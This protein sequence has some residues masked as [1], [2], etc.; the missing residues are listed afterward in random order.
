MS[1]PL[2]P[3]PDRAEAAAT[4]LAWGRRLLRRPA[5]EAMVRTA[6]SPGESLQEA[7]RRLR[8]AREERGLS[9]R[10]LALETR[11]SITV[12]E[13]L[14]KGWRDRLPEPTYLRTMLTLLEQ[15]LELQPASLAAALPAHSRQQG[16]SGPDP[17]LRRVSLGSIELFTTW[18]GVALYGLLCLL[19]IYG[20]N[21]QQ[22]RLAARGAFAL[23]P[24]PPQPAGSAAPAT[25]SERDRSRV[26]AAYPDIRPLERAGQGQALERLRQESR[27]RPAA[28]PASPASGGSG[29]T[30]TPAAAAGS[31]AAGGDPGPPAGAADQPPPD[32]ASP[33]P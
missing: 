4:L 13:A 11:I 22:Q 24:I 5:P 12:L 14:E 25:A 8:S 20:L 7:G 33:R 9:L 31:A 17:R 32:S 26:L 3:L 19:L 1:S 18:Q 2:P 27:P 15:H 16:R 6:G 23:R 21:R 10:Q 29:S 30:A 28:P